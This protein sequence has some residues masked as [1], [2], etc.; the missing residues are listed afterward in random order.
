MSQQQKLERVLDLLL[1]EDSDQAAELLHQ[2]IVEK[3]RTI[4]ESIVDEEDDAE[5]SEGDD[6]GGEPDEDFTQE[7]GAD[8]DEID[9]DEEQ[10][11]EPESDEDD[12]FGDE[13]ELGDEEGST[14][15]RIE[16]LE[17]QLADL[18]AEFDQ[19][20]G[21]EMQEPE[22]ADMAGAEDEF[23]GD[24]EFSGEDEF[25]D[26]VGGEEPEDT[27]SPD[28]SGEEQVVGEV[29]AKFHEKKKMPAL[30]K[31]PEKKDLKKG[32]KVD[33]ETKFLNAVSDTGQKGTAKLVGTGKGMT[34]GAEQTQSPYTRSPS[35][36]DF[37]G[38]PTK[39][40]SGTGGEYGKYNGDSATDKTV[41]DNVNLK[42]K[43]VSTKADTTPKYTGGKSAGEGFSK[44]PLTK[45][46][47]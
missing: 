40:G 14:E 22:H 43:N 9:S 26:V 28:F 10:D 5:G 7:I 41:T 19:L 38:G 15:E 11:G 25:G 21:E 35:K 12:E 8:K 2:I 3:A 20:M 18:R 16:D 37:G 46:P 4:Y 33:E 47:T 6:V 44:S 32:K 39:I 36:K 17:S 27:E 30:K 42:G 13:S 23:G 29:V 34:L 24:N 1:S 45:K 31:A